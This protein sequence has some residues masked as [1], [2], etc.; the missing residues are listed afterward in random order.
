[1]ITGE[2]RAAMIYNGDALSLQKHEPNIRYIIPDEG[3]I[4][5]VDYLAAGHGSGNKEIVLKFINYI[6]EPRI[7]AKMPCLYNLRAQTKLRKSIFQQ[8]F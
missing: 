6:N 5:W 7:A 1:M 4:V 8:I 2:I 3:G